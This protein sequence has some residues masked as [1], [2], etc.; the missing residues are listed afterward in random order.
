MWNKLKHQ[1]RSLV[2]TKKKAKDQARRES[3]VPMHL[4]RTDAQIQVGGEGLQSHAPIIH[5]RIV[6][7]EMTPLGLFVAAEKALLVG[8]RV[9]LTMDQPKRFFVR[10]RI[11]SCLDEGVDRK[12]IQEVSYRYRVG[13]KFDFKSA[14]ERAA[15]AAYCR[16]LHA[17]YIHAREVA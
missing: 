12:I 8:Q 7:N 13:I 6:L 15:V 4:V 16:E 3:Q 2:Q 14:N 5:A 17:K 1:I 10:G 9:S 11:T